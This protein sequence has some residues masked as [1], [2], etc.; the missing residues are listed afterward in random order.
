[1]SE[2]FER[3]F[4]ALSEIRHPHIVGVLEFDTASVRA[5]QLW[6]LAM[7]YVVGVPL[8]EWSRR[9]Q[10]QADAF[11]RRLQ[12]AIDLADALR[13]AHEVTY[14]DQVG[15]EAHGVLHGDVKPAN[16]LVDRH[17]RVKLLDF[18][19]VDIQRLLDPRVVPPEYLH[20][21]GRRRELTGAFGTP[22]YMA[23][24]AG[25]PW[26]GHYEN[27]HLQPSRL[28]KNEVWPAFRF[29]RYSFEIQ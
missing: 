28:R 20:E 16:V 12:A 5:F 8:D 7:E 25:K 1:M 9:I 26:P 21:D 13:A 19:L 11:D 2:L 18:L 4:R 3:G 22:G 14:T 17:G 29:F 27:R 10:G 6:Y 23:P 15:F 24:R